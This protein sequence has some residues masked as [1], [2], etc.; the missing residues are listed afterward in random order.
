MHGGG[1]LSRKEV[2]ILEEFAKEFG[3]KGKTT[4]VYCLASQ[5]FSI[6]TEETLHDAD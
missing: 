3:A 6:T 4:D 1:S 2:G 5:L